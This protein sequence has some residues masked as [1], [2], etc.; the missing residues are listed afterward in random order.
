MAV[1]G[2]DIPYWRQLESEIFA[3]LAEQSPYGVGWWAP[4]PGTTRRIFI[5]DQLYA[6]TTSVS[7]N[8]IEAGLHW[9]EFLDYTEREAERHANAVKILNGKPLLEPPVPECPLDELG[10]P[11]VR[12]HVA[13]VIRALSGAL[14]CMAGTVIGVAALPINIIRADFKMVRSFLQKI[15]NGSA[16]GEKQ[17]AAFG[18]DFTN[19]LAEAG[20]QGWLDWMIAYRN[21]IV[22][23]GRRIELGQYLPK[24]VV[25]YGPDGQH[26]PRTDRVTHLPRD[27][28]RS[29]IEVFRDSPQSLVLTEDAVDTLQGLMTSTRGFIDMAA[30]S[31]SELWNWRRSHPQELYQPAAQWSNLSA[32]EPIGFAGYKPNSIQ[33]SASAAM[34]MHPIQVRRFH[35]AALDDG[36]RPLWTSF[37]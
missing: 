21:M 7:Q 31:L 26:V 15:P 35:A 8:M 6:C 14:D 32:T 19:L 33:L 12:A 30:K 37:D 11:L 3:D 23:R 27:P 25:L 20:P 2:V 29:D 18:K 9:L 24:R 28:L 13:G 16:D 5:S 22:H 10:T 17:Q 34:T 36:S 4:H 1:L